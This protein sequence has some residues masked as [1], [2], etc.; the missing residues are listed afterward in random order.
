M[1]RT[2]LIQE[3]TQSI[4]AIPCP[5]PLRVAIDG[6]DAAGKTILANELVAPLQALGRK[7]IRA[8]IDGFHNPRHIRYQRGADSPEGYYLD[9]FNY[10]LLVASLLEPLGPGGNRMYWTAGFDFRQDTPL[11]IPLQQASEDAILLFEGVFLLRPELYAY[12]DFKI[13]VDVDFEVSVERACQRDLILFGSVEATRQ[14]YRTR[15]VPG[16]QLYL[17]ACSPKTQADLVIVN[18]DLDNPLLCKIQQA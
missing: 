6:V 3:L 1:K 18:N 4:H 15:Y 13:F 8:S 5:H 7:V 17:A 11:D 16:Q 9:S 12:W 10:N 14:R 2:Q